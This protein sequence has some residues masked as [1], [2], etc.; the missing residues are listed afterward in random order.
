MPEWHN[1][2]TRSAP[3]RCNA[4]TSARAA[5]TISTVINFPVMWASSH[6]AICG[7]AT[8]I[9][10]TFSARFAPPSSANNRSTMIEGGNQGA[11]SARRTLEQVTG[12]RAAA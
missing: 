4:A 9:T 8:P 7:G 2:T 1:A 11:P 10:P 3:R 6:C 5:S 12:N